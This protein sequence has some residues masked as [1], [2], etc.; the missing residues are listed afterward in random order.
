VNAASQG[1]DFA[2]FYLAEFDRIVA[3]IQRHV[4]GD[5]EDVAQEAS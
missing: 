1:S 2:S 4:G 3:S 5:A